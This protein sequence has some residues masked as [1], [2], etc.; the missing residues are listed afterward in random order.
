VKFMNSLSLDNSPRL[1]LAP[2]EALK[3]ILGTGPVATRVNMLNMALR[4]LRSHEEGS[5]WNIG[6]L[7]E[8]VKGLHINRSVLK[9]KFDNNFGTLYEKMAYNPDRDLIYR[10]EITDA[11]K[12]TIRVI[13]SHFEIVAMARDDFGPIILTAKEANIS[14]LS[15]KLSF[16][17]LGKALFSFYAFQSD[18]FEVFKALLVADSRETYYQRLSLLLGKS[19]EADVTAELT[20]TGLLSRLQIIERE[21]ST[22]APSI[23]PTFLELVSRQYASPEELV[24]ALIGRKSRSNLGLKDF[25]FMQRAVDTILDR[26]SDNTSPDSTAQRNVLLYGP[27]GTGKTEIT[28]VIAKHLGVP[29]YFVE[30]ARPELRFRLLLR[31]ALILRLTAMPGILVLDEAEEVLSDPEVS[32]RGRHDSK[33]HL[34]AELLKLGVPVIFITNRLDLFDGSAIRRLL[35]AIRMGYMPLINRA[36][37]IGEQMERRNLGTIDEQGFLRLAVNTGPKPTIFTGLV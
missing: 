36:R 2:D 7:F 22:P 19:D 37:V 3:K 31:A 30:E 11:I 29:A 35:P 14:E 17:E 8:V 15:K 10:A 23:D 34:N 26:L 25:A 27:P 6:E 9:L 32:K 13:E 4:V 5:I 21:P 33:G 1:P 20:D 24:D 28:A 16:S 18:V 12:K